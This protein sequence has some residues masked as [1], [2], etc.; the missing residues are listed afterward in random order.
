MNEEKMQDKSMVAFIKDVELRIKRYQ[1]NNF[2][3]WCYWKH[4]L[5]RVDPDNPLLEVGFHGLPY[6]GSYYS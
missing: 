3:E 6:T 5:E 4:A 1:G 2:Q